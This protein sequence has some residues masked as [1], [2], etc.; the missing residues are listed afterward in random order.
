MDNS[1]QLMYYNNFEM[2]NINLIEKFSLLIQ[3]QKYKCKCFLIS[4]Y[5]L[6]VLPKNLNN[7]NNYIVEV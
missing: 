3:N 2:I 5:M 6:I 4:N 1:S 7:K